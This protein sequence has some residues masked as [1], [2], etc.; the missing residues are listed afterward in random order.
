[1]LQ[2]QDDSVAGEVHYGGVLGDDQLSIGIQ[3]ECRGL[4]HNLQENKISL[5]LIG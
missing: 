1:M 2:W 5:A 3:L 4:G